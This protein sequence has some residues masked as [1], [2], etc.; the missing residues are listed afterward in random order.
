MRLALL[1]NFI[2]PYRVP[3]YEEME[4]RCADF[5]IFI[6]AL[7]EK[8][9]EWKPDWKNLPVQVQRSFAF[10]GHWRHP[11]GFSEQLTIH[12]PVDTIP[13][14]RRFRPEV[15]LSGEMG[16]RTVQAALYRRFFP[17][18]RLVIWAKLSDFSE[19]GRGRMRHSLRRFLLRSADAVVVNGEGGARYI[20]RFGVDAERIFRAPCTTD[21][22]PFLER[23]AGRGPETRHRLLYS[24]VFSERKNIVPFLDIAAG[25]AERHPSRQVEIS[26]LG[27]GPLQS[28]LADFRGPENLHVR[29]LGSV[30]YQRLP[31]IYREHGILAFPTLADEWGMVVIE[32]LASGMPVLGSVYSQAVEELVQNH[33]NGWTFRPDSRQETFEALDAALT[34]SAGELDD[35]AEQARASVCHITPAVVAERIVAAANYARRSR[36]GCV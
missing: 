32:A 15:I 9:R 34:R 2:P 13:R 5:R 14:L 30:P 18:S 31:E 24:G 6:S 20:R 10:S 36:A 8:G 16:M 23:P 25:W 26:V 29:V 7:T 3:V 28:Q 1:T 27:H 19:Q 17:E 33:R 21:L 12:V 4:R 11:H 22:G 35:M